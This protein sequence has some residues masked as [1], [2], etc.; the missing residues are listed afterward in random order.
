MNDYE[1]LISKWWTATNEVQRV[2]KW[3]WMDGGHMTCHVC[4]AWFMN[5]IHTY[6][7]THMVGPQEKDRTVYKLTTSNK[8]TDNFSWHITGLT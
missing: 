4:Y 6:I 2:V 3:Q 7:F 8:W 5:A 1:Q